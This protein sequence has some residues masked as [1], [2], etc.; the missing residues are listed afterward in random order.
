MFFWVSWSTG[1]RKQSQGSGYFNCPNCASRQPAELFQFIRTTYLYGFLPM[2]GGSPVGDEIYYCRA[3]RRE[4]A[5]DGLYGYD[6]GE[7]ATARTWQC[8]KCDRDIPYE[9]FD[10]PHCGYRFD[11]SR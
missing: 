3:C 10:C 4:F 8:F 6:F 11:P 9:R 7:E 1:P 5:N 2:G